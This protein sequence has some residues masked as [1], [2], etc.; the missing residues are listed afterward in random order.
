MDELQEIIKRKLS[1]YSNIDIIL[2]K[3]MQ[4]K[5]LSAVQKKVNDT[6]VNRSYGFLSPNVYL[7]SLVFEN[8]CSFLYHQYKDAVIFEK[9]TK[10]DIKSIIATSQSLIQRP[11][12]KKP[13]ET[14]QGFSEPCYDNDYVII[15]RCEREL[16]LKRSYENSNDKGRIVFEGLLPFRIETNPLLYKCLAHNIW[17]N[18]FGVNEQMIQGLHIN[19]NSIEPLFIIWVNSHLLLMLN[20]KLDDYKKGLRAL[21]NEGEVILLFR[22]WRDQLIDKHSFD[23]TNANIAKLEGCDLILRTDY[24][25]QLKKIIPDLVFYSQV[26]G[27]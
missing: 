25:N 10:L 24:F 12:I 7:E 4:E 11:D 22:R 27:G 1:R 5:V 2:P 26:V 13:S 3:N 9:N 21:N 23:G 18:D 14:I 16:I 8:V 17:T 6:F 19:I 20:L 15:A